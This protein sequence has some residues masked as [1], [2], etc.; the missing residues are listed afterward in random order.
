[1]ILSYL[2]LA[3]AVVHGVDWN[4]PNIVTAKGVHAVHFPDV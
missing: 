3:L 4:T 1:M 2:L